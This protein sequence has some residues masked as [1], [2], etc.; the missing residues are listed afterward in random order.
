MASNW[1]A[2]A[3]LGKVFCLMQH[4]STFSP[5]MYCSVAYWQSYGGG[6]GIRK[7]ATFL[8]VANPSHGGTFEE[9]F[10]RWLAFHSPYARSQAKTGGEGPSLFSTRNK[11]SHRHGLRKVWMRRTV[12]LLNSGY[13]SNAAAVDAAATV[14]CRLK[15]S[16]YEREV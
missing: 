15:R 3:L 8:N 14:W 12:S 7:Q 13:A 1:N 2:V 10:A 5:R 6:A 9:N 16:P 4:L 11:I